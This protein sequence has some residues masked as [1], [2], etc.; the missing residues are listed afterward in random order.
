M[1]YTTP[2]PINLR[3]NSSAKAIVNNILHNSKASQYDQLSGYLSS[4]RVTVFAKISIV[5]QKMK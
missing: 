4:A 1:N 5:V 3:T 2:R